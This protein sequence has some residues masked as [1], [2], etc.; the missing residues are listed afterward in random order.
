[1]GADRRLGAVTTV[2]EALAGVA[3]LA[4]TPSK[5][6]PTTVEV[7]GRFVHS[8]YDPVAEAEKFVD[9]QRIAPGDTIFLYGVGLGYHL[10]FLLDAV[11]PTG[12]LLA[13]EANASLLA[14]ALP[15]IDE[16][17][18]EDPRLTLIAGSDEASFLRRLAAAFAR[19][20]DDGKVVIHPG[21]AAAAPPRWE[22]VATAVEMIRMERRFPFLMGGAERANRA[23]NLERLFAGRGIVSLTG[24][25]RGAPAIVVGAG[26]SLDRDIAAVAAV[27]GKAAVIVADTAFPPLLAAGIE[28]T[29]VVTVDPKS[30]S[31]YHF[32]LAGRT[33][34]PLAAAAGA[35]PALLARW[36]GP[37][38]FGFT[39]PDR[40][41]PEARRWIERRIG[42]FT[43]GG[44]VSAMALELALIMGAGAVTAVGQDFSFPAGRAYADGTAPAILGFTLA[45]VP[46]ADR[47]TEVDPFGRPVVTTVALTGYRREF[48]RLALSTPVSVTTLST[49]APPTPGVPLVHI[50]HEGAVGLPPLPL[51]PFDRCGEPVGR[52]D[53]TVVSLL[54]ADR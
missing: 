49:F 25:L 19:V 52:P 30:A 26:P 32:D 27:A 44:S 12:R 36:T 54:A 9:A 11:G 41:P 34:L 33:D 10:P 39:G 28:P 5:A 43:A 3:P 42:F 22:K 48:E 38:F 35:H 47:R 18:R 14:T 2:A 15:L 37:L 21:A 29:L 16:A 45:A 20:G 23:A 46:V 24:L 40:Y 17:T 53:E 50:P 6:G 31:L 1:M 7:D 8:R 13:A 4:T 51:I